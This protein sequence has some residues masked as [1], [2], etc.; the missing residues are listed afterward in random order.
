MNRNMTV[1]IL[2][3]VEYEVLGTSVC[4]HCPLNGDLQKYAEPIAIMRWSIEH[5]DKISN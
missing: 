3:C 1:N 5:C 4:L 2:H